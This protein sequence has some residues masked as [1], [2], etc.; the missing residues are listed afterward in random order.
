[1]QVTMYQKMLAHQTISG[2]NGFQIRLPTQTSS[3]LMADPKFMMVDSLGAIRKCPNTMLRFHQ[4]IFITER[5]AS[6][7]NSNPF[8]SIYKMPSYNNFII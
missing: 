3:Y 8:Q 2:M 4:Y 7:K 1:M 6:L 5:L